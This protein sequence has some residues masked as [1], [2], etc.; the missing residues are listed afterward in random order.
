MRRIAGFAAVSVV[1]GLVAVLCAFGAGSITS[2]SSHSTPALVAEVNV[3]LA[4]GDVRMDNLESG[5]TTGNKTFNGNLTVTTNV[6]ATGE[7]R[8]DG[9][10]AITGGDATTGLMVLKASITTPTL[11]LHTNTFAVT[12]GA[13][14]VVSCTYTED[15]GDV[16]PIFLG[17]VTASNVIVNAV[18]GK[19]YGYI[20]VGT[21]P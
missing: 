21:R 12:F 11:A 7:V 8:A 4:E 17:T 3:A 20:A 2:V 9:K 18:A 19:N 1:V 16:R 6:L 13:A 5:T 15:P 14:P 10:Y